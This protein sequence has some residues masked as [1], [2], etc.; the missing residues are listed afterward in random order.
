M[1]F[2]NDF[3]E[4]YEDLQ[5][6]IIELDSKGRHASED[7]RMAKE[8][9]E[10][11]IKE[12]KKVDQKYNTENNGSEEMLLDKMSLI[13]EIDNLKLFIN[14]NL[15]KIDNLIRSKEL[16]SN[17]N[18]KV[19]LKIEDFNEKLEKYENK[20]YSSYYNQLPDYYYDIESSLTKNG[21]CLMCG[22][23]S[24][25]LKLRHELKVREKKCLVCDSYLNIQNTE[26][27]N[28]LISQINTL[29]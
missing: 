25:Q 21:H 3:Y 24:K 27:T 28:R 9:F 10:S 18:E 4:I 1:L 20:L 16:T 14:N 22:A 2:D 5:K 29:K 17:E 19:K 12:K 15:N 23:K 6:E 13:S 11:L 26:D 7:L 8:A